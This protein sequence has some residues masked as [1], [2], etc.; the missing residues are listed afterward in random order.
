MKYANVL[1]HEYFSIPLLFLLVVSP[2]GLVASAEATA[3]QAACAQSVVAA[4][5]TSTPVPYSYD[6]AISLAATSSA[7]LG[8]ISGY[9]ASFSSIGTNWRESP[10]CSVS[11]IYFSITYLLN[12]RNDSQY[13][14]TLG[15]NPGTGIVFSAGITPAAYHSLPINQTSSTYSGYAI[16]QDSSYDPYV[17]YTQVGWWVPTVHAPSGNCG[18]GSGNPPGCE[19]A[20]WTGLQNSTYDGTNH[21]TTGEVIQTGTDAECNSTCTSGNYNGWA[22]YLNGNSAGIQQNLMH[23]C[24]NTI[25]A[26][27]EMY[28]EVAN[29]KII[30]GT[31][32]KTFYTYLE[33]YRTSTWCDW[34]VSPST[35]CGSSNCKIAGN[36][37]FADY[38]AETPQISSTLSYE[39]PKFRAPSG[40]DLFFGA[41]MYAYNTGTYTYYNDG[42]WLYSYMKNCGLQCIQNTYVT[43]M[44]SSGS[45]LYQASFNETWK[46]SQNTG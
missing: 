32:G 16:A 18:T 9:N 20:E 23:T 11:F 3:T 31:T 26:G 5:T 45:P 46:S 13:L 33:D 4:K 37:K 42:Y 39:L 38:F 8:S 21:V 14:L 29:Q 10:T 1:R 40:D 15:A 17:N 44:S 22:E 24:A 27:D 28:G 30:N 7:F 34:H 25:A 41:G 2:V 35:S 43:A 19:L 12:A 36:E 6:S